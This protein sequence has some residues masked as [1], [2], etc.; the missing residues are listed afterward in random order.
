MRTTFLMKCDLS[1]SPKGEQIDS[2]EKHAS[3]DMGKGAEPGK[4]GSLKRRQGRS[5]A[6]EA[7]KAPA[8]EARKVTGRNMENPKY[9]SAR[10]FALQEPPTG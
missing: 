8:G 1:K 9:Q 7:G 2:G 6:K 5:G 4:K 10:F 3:K